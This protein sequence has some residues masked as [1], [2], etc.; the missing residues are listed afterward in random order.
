MCHTVGK[1][2]FVHCHVH[3]PYSLLDGDA[4]IQ[5]LMEHVVSIGQ[6]AVATT[7]HGTTASYYEFQSK[8]K[9]A[10]VKPIFGMEAYIVAR[11]RRLTDKD[12]V[13]DRKPYHLLLIAINATGIKNLNALS[14]IAEQQGFYYRPRIDW[15][16]LEAYSDGLVVTSSCMAGEIP[17]Y[18]MNERDK[19]TNL[20]KY[21]SDENAFELAKQSVQWYLDVF[22]DRFFF[23]VQPRFNSPLQD[24]V[25]DGIVRLAQYAKNELGVDIPIIATTDAHYV[26]QSD[27]KAHDALLCIQTGSRIK[28]ENRMRFDEN[29][30]YIMTADEIASFFPQNPEFLTNTVRLANMV[31]ASI[32]STGYKLPHF[33]VP[34][35]ETPASALRRLVEIGMRWRYGDDAELHRD[36]VEYELQ[37][38]EKMGFPSY[39]LVV[40]DLCEYAYR[41]KIPFNTRGSAAGSIIAYALGITSICPMRNGLLFER[42]LNPARVSM[43]DIDLDYPDDRRGEMIA[44]TKLRYGSENVAG[45]VTFSVLHG[46]SAL[47]DTCRVMDIPIPVVNRAVDVIPK[48]KAPPLETFAEALEENFKEYPALRE[49]FNIAVE[50]EGL[51]RHSSV[52]PAAVVVTDKPVSDYVPLFRSTGKTKELLDGITQY[53]MDV[54]ESMGL[55]KID[56]LGLKT[57]TV[58]R[59]TLEMIK[60]RHGVDWDIEEIPYQHSGEPEVDA[61]IEKALDVIRAG[62]TV[63]V[64]QLEGDAMT[65]MFKQMQPKNYDNIIAGIALY[66]P[67][68]MAFIPDYIKRLHGE[69][70]VEYL[71][72]LLEPILRDTYGVIV[73]QEQVMRIAVDLFGYD[74]SQADYLRKAVA[75]KKEKDMAEHRQ[76]FFDNRHIHGLDEEIVQTIWDAVEYFGNYGFNKGHASSYA[77]LTMITALLSALYPAEFLAS[78]LEV[79]LGDFDKLDLVLRACRDKGIDVKAPDVRYSNVGFDIV[80]EDGKPSIVCGLSL[81]KNVGLSPATIIVE[82]RHSG[83]RNIVD[84]AEAVPLH[85]VNKKALESLIYA[86]AF[87][88]TGYSRHMVNALLPSLREHAKSYHATSRSNQPTLFDMTTIDKPT[89]DLGYHIGVLGDVP[90]MN[91]IDKLEREKDL[92]GFYI[93]ERPTDQFLDK[94]EYYETV[95]INRIVSESPNDNDYV[96]HNIYIGGQVTRIHQHLTKNGNQMAFVDVTDY[97]QSAG[98]MSVVVFPSQYEYLKSRLVEGAVVLVYGEFQYDYG[99]YSLPTT[100]LYVVYSPND[101]LTPEE[102]GLDK[103]VEKPEPGTVQREDY[104]DDSLI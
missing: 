66:R 36:R 23:E 41:K 62:D 85:K 56:F 70:P 60:R 98:V 12:K 97:R 86:G 93:N 37:V 96:G 73:Y 76:R 3:T 89:Y 24:K 27:A 92:V 88:W 14:T 68:P 19:Q 50:I 63:G 2:G 42:F 44:Y 84:V 33:A 48:L 64:F 34:E 71:H 40:W 49:A 6:T 21:G 7:D 61:M 53:P 20:P 11:G 77:R 52:H 59:R 58:I 87:D 67:G 99:R 8:A 101:A 54:V 22:G 46:R 94:L 80:E 4:K 35:G 57:L 95:D 104:Y 47:R 91:I 51:P 18:I 39:F 16:L 29:S 43:P 75:K 15:E 32:E 26:K 10:G 1:G 9:Q 82:S 65:S 103:P 28:D 100:D 55:L 72:P 90:D 81:V 30:Y 83:M 17:Q 74:G 5:N 78:I 69:A 31:D 79:Y 25:N 38:I 102:M 45:I 13:K